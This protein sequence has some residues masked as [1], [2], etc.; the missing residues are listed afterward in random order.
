MKVILL[1]ISHFVVSAQLRPERSLYTYH[2]YV[3][4]VTYHHGRKLSFG[5]PAPPPKLAGTFNNSYIYVDTFAP[6]DKDEIT[7]ILVQEEPKNS[8]KKGDLLI[9]P[10]VTLPT[11][12][13][14]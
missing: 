1:F 7:P 14:V 9:I 10:R 3:P 8:K 2:P 11:N 12:F 5:P 4:D 6:Q 13:I